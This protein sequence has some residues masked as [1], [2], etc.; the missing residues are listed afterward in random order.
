MQMV[1]VRPFAWDPVA[2]EASKKDFLRLE[3]RSKPFQL[4]SKKALLVPQKPY[5]SP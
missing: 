5:Q 4:F 3:Q 1:L 2:L